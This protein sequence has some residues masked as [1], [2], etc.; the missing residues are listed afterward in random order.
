MEIQ[1][2]ETKK[3]KL[4]QVYKDEQLIAIN[5]R[6]SQQK[7]IGEHFNYKLIEYP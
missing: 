6:F 5:Y 3:D 4:Y 2:E 7:I 1:K